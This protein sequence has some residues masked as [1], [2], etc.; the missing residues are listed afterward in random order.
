V[1]YRAL[2]PITVE[3]D[4][5]KAKLGGLR[6]QI[7]LAVLLRSANRVISQDS[8]IDSVWAGKPPE[9]SRATVQSYIY[10]LRRVLGPDAIVRRGDGYSIEVDADTFDVLAFENSVAAGTRLLETDP[11][12]ARAH[13]VDGLDLWF[14][15]AYGG[16]DHPEL[17]SEI[18]RLGEIRVNAI[19]SRIEADLALG[20]AGELVAELES[21]VRDHPLRERFWGQLMLALYRSGRQAESLRAFQT[22]RAHLVDHLGIEP[23][24]ELQRLETRI[25]D[26]DPTLLLSREV[27]TTEETDGRR[28]SA[29]GY[30]LR[31]VIGSGAVGLVYR[32][33]QP[34]IGREVAIK[35]I[36]ADF[37]N[38]LAFVSRFE[39]EAQMVANLEH[40][41]LVP[42]HDYWRDPSGAYLVMPLMR[43]GSLEDS[44]RTGGWNLEPALRLLD[45]LGSAL[46]YAHRRGL[47][48][49]DLKPSN[50]LLDEDGNAYLS[51]FGIATRHGA[52]VDLIPHSKRLRSPEEVAGEPATVRSEIFALG[53]LA[54]ELFS[55][56]PAI[57]TTPVPDLTEARSDINPT[58]AAVIKQAMAVDPED[59]FAKVDE[60]LREAR[61]AAGVDVVAASEVVED[62]ESIRNPYKGLRAFAE[63]DALD[64]HGRATLVDDLMERIAHHRLVTV[65]GPSGSGKSSVVRAGLIPALR[66]GRLSGSRDWL[67]TD[68]FPGSYPFEELEA[69]LSR[70]AV[71]TP[72][73]M[74][75][76]LT[77]PNGLLRLSKQILPGEDSTLLIV[78]DQFEE[79]FSTVRSE[80]TRRRF[81]DSLIVVANDERSR[82]RVV[83]TLRADFLDR[84]LGY[85][86]FAEALSDGII[87]VGP[88]TREGLAQAVA[89]PARTVGLDLEPG[90][91]GQIIAD[92][93]GQPG[94][95]PL[96]QYALTEMFSHR[97]RVTLTIAGYEATG[98]VAGALGRRAEELYDGLSPAGRQTAREVFLRLVSVDEMG[99]VTRRRARQSEL[100]SLA[101][102]RG[103]LEMVLSAFASF[104]LLTFDRDPV[105]RG[106]TVEVAHEALLTEWSRL[107][108]WIEDARESL[109]LAR[110]V[111][112]SAQEWIESDED[113][114]YLLRGI[115]LEDV[116]A[117]ATS[118]SVVLTNLETR[119][120]AASVEQRSAELESTRRRRRRILASLT[121]GLV[122]VSFLA[123]MAFLQRGVAEHEALQAR[124]RELAAAS[125]GQLDENRELALLIAAEAFDASTRGGAQP[126][127]EAVSA[128]ARAMANWRLVSRFPAGPVLLPVASPDGSPIAVSS[129][130][131][132][133]DVNVFG[134]D[135]SLIGTLSGPA[136]PSVAAGDVTFSPDGETIA[137]AY[138]APNNDQFR[139]VS[140]GVP[141]IVIFDLTDQS[142]LL[143]VDT[144]EGWRHISYS[145]DGTRLAVSLDRTVRILD[146]AD[147]S[148]ISTFTA[149]ALIGDPQF[150]GN[151][152]IVVPIEGIGFTT[153]SVADGS[154]LDHVEVPE[155]NPVVTAMNELHTHVA[156]RS[157]E[158]LRVSEIASGDVVFDL[159][160][161]SA[162]S[163]ALDPD[164]TR[165]AYSGFDPN[166]YV[167]P[168]GVGEAELELAGTFENVYSLSFIDEKNLLSF[169]EDALLWD[170]SPEGVEEL[171][172]IPLHEP[173]WGY[174]ISPEERLLTYS[175]STNNGGPLADPVDGLRLVDLVTG[176]ETMISQGEYNAVSAGLRLVNADF[177]MV[178]SLTPDGES[179]MRRLPSWEVL[180]EFDE[181]RGAL[182]LTPDNTR[183]VLSGWSCGT[184]GVPDSAYSS[185]VD[186]ESGKEIFVLPYQTMFSADFNPDGAFEGGSLLAVTDQISVGVW[187]MADGTLLGSLDR[188]EY[189]E[190]GNLM[191]ANFDPTGRYLVG[192]STG[193]VVWVAD[194]ERV[195]AGVDMADA[196][197][198][199][200]Q[201]HT[202]AAPVPAINGAGVVA[203]A[204]FD[205]LVRLWDLDSGN[206]ILEFEAEVGVPVVRFSPD[207]TELLYPDGLSIR[208]LPVDPHQ[209]RQMAD[210]LLTRGFLPDECA[211]YAIQTRCDG[212]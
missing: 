114:S 180:R 16:V 7:V 212:G 208:R 34:S 106:P 45:Q 27:A 133:A 171:G 155:L 102:D 40:P 104:R 77:Q 193:G 169:G 109:V 204:G 196:L 159:T 33:Y 96:L 128:M 132:L 141:D 185:V 73:G 187:D 50:V 15:T 172:G 136:D 122:L 49:G 13:L 64:F 31:E 139:S 32:A 130:S 207:G 51:D 105:T 153:I 60:F 192:G 61:R 183:V 158:H 4:G 80:E 137:I 190:F 145:P 163:V 150:L 103:G 59:R 99:A 29:R 146:S 161:P 70:V 23:G 205:G 127:T 195:V 160:A 121:V 124:V 54:F 115:R 68:M 12:S 129:K 166:I 152:E 36:H 135:G 30:E 157:G 83:T 177:T 188:N 87:T 97:E 21:L 174:Q 6:Q 69:A 198:F 202:G 112:E 25:L 65:V 101:V 179:T 175:V 131:T 134:A 200:R 100:V 1:R 181:C 71:R 81:I 37:T 52:R 113:P 28:E 210:R 123:L 178:G 85:G 75:S 20:R 53:A 57:G 79:L 43:G 211:R 142:R 126:N 118:A 173:Q 189:D 116:E 110:R 162:L 90:L 91:V 22:A 199:N 66:S 94:A 167:L 120:I 117:W 168:I 67:V 209:L 191:V 39:R 26:H 203:S 56:I 156:Y 47:L 86:D 154:V 194:L 17:D 201:A 89:A 78:I 5:H 88:P 46:A 170:V 10:N 151:D 58:L 143:E 76:E 138:S 24:A 19:E 144:E 92:V 206:L 186:L 18:K 72:P 8:L 38:D 98:G 184:S 147:A 82:V 140:A 148:E 182:A 62:P 125:E 14:G 42:L 55:G 165:L 108:G 93:E 3:L 197:V 63:E 74:L 2:G 84:P 44:L 164:A 95:L 176:E 9:A 149:R 119:Y 11:A 35:V 111:G 107:R 48:H 41:H